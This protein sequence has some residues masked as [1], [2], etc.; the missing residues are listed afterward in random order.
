M[1]RPYIICHMLQSIDGRIS[2]QFFHDENTQNLSSIYKEMSNQFTA[3]GIIYGSVT[4]MDTYIIVTQGRGSD[5][6]LTR[7]KKNIV[8]L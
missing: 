8:R 5:F 1:N 7:K 2:G 3:D 4:V 6:R